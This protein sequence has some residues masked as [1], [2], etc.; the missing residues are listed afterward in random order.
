MHTS[1]S[2]IQPNTGS[3]AR[4]VS[5]LHST[6]VHNFGGIAD[7]HTVNHYKT[8]AASSECAR[9]VQ[10]VLLKSVA[11]LCIVHFANTE[12]CAQGVVA[13]NDEPSDVHEELPSDVE[14]DEEEVNAN[15][16]Q[17]LV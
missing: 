15:E 10:R 3:A 7:Q 11:Y 9:V 14:E 17:E 2:Q 16:S 13:R 6:G 4:H 1:R 5:Y 8:L 12:Q